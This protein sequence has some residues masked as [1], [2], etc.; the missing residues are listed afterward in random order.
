M[1]DVSLIDGQVFGLV[2]AALLSKAAEYGLGRHMLYLSEY[3]RLQT[4]KYGV[5]CLGLGYISPMAGRVAFCITMLYVA[6]TDRKVHRWAKYVTATLI[7]LQVVIN[8]LAFIVFYAQCGSRLHVLWHPEV[9]YAH[10]EYCMDVSIQTDLGY[11]QGAFNC[12]TDAYL[13]FLPALLIEHTKL[14]IKKK[15]GLAFLLCLSVAAL[16]AA[17]GKTYEAKA[18][19]EV[20]DYTC[21]YFI[22]HPPLKI[23]T[24]RVAIGDLCLYTIWIEIELNI[25]I[26]VASIPLLR[27]II[28]RFDKRRHR[29]PDERS[30]GWDT[31]T[32]SSV[33][34]KG[35]SKSR[36]TAVST[37][38][39]ENIVPQSFEAFNMEHPAHGIRVTQEVSVTYQPSDVQFVHAA[40][41]GL[42]QGEI[43]NPRL[44]HR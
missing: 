14:S 41:V 29:L 31:A 7:V 8:I 2:H 9:L 17:I 34:S 16:T 38:S 21:E 39:E 1:S 42:V 24:D 28:A 32:F 11:F 23:S 33:Y 35:K 22:E 6:G 43:A 40:I 18:L 44:V 26:V 10:P 3:E 13:T 12:L 20:A 27:P 36:M 19:S 5:L 37:S 15:I 25:V 4:L 30:P